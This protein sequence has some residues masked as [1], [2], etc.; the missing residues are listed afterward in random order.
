[1]SFVCAENLFFRTVTSLRQLHFELAL[2]V[3]LPRIIE[4]QASL[5]IVEQE[6]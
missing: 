4:V 5:A 6:V 1:M 3:F 2:F